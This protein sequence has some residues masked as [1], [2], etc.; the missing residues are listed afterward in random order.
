MKQVF[1][2]MSQYPPLKSLVFLDAAIRH[3]SFSLAAEELCVTPGAVGQQIQKLE[4]WL[5]TP[6]FTRQIRQVQPTVEGL[7]YWRRIQPALAQIADASR[8]LKQRRSK[9]VSLSMPPSFAAKWLTRRLAGFVTG[10]PDVELHLSATTALVNFERDAIDLSIRYFQDDD[11]DLDATL[12]YRYEGRVY[13]RPGYAAALDLQQANDL[14]RATL[15]DTATQPYW[16]PWLQRFSQLDEARIAAIPCIHFDQAIVAIEAAKQGQGVV[17]T[18]PFLVEEELAQG[19]LIE[20]FGHCLQLPTGY[21]V[22][23]HRKLAIRHAAQALKD[24]L[25]EEARGAPR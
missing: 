2:T 17:M 23:H 12:L 24:W 19:T 3:N 11:P 21:Y 18:C 16:Q 4:E 13:C 22:V 9:S 14:Q 7:A 25:I 20:P 1:Y 10:H 8:E 6:L 15:L 5:G